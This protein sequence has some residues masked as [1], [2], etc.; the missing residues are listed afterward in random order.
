MEN[1][2][3]HNFTKGTQVIRL[4][5]KYPATVESTYW[6]DHLTCRYNHNGGTFF[7]HHRYLQLYTGDSTM[8]A[9]KTLYSYTKPDGTI[10][11]GHHI[12]TNSQNE[13]IIEVKGTNEILVL[14]AEALTEIL[15]F[16][17]SAKCGAKETQFIGTPDTVST[18]D[19]LVSIGNS[20]PQFYIVT[21]VDTKDKTA[22]QRFKG[23]KVNTTP[24]K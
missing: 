1:Q 12:G 9:K 4:K 11:Y 7:I 6:Q 16:T 15:P 8:S 21:A 20:T 5:G 13:F 2:L 19:I 18:G 24:L 14:P 17:F 22:S 10:I 23:H 3:H